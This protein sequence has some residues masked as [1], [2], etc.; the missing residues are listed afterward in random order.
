MRAALLLLVV[1]G[2]AAVTVVA[3]NLQRIV[4][5]SV[6]TIDQYPF[7]VSLLYSWTGIGNYIQEC[8][9]A[10][11][12]NRAILTAAH[13]LMGDPPNRWR[14]RVGST[15]A[16]SGGV[17][18]T[19][20]RIIRHSGFNRRTV[21]NDVAIIQIVG[22]FS[23]NNNVRAGYIAGPNY[24]PTDNSPVWAIGWGR[25][26]SGGTR[27]EQL[28]HVQ[29]WIVN[30]AVCRSRYGSISR[31]VTDNM[32]CSGHLDVGGRDTCQFDSGGPLLHN[33]VI[34]GIT[35]WGQGCGLPRFPGVSTRVSRYTTWI[36]THS[37]S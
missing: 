14:S 26:T 6:T 20:S 17:V 32:I 8:G 29:I 16:N 23:F 35:S 33:N 28:R 30:Q 19:T 9:G 12:N 21:D 10:I 2:V 31:T 27:S 3:S 1:L 7:G 22:T 11:V 25:T 34:I 13:C 5:G 18:H 36:R 37:E 15:N 4:G 24:N